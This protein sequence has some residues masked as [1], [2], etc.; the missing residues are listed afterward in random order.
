MTQEKKLSRDELIRQVAAHP[1]GKVKVAVTDID[2]ILRGKYIHKEKFLSIVDGGFGFCDVVF[3]WDSSDLSYDNTDFTGW[4]TGYPDAKASLDLDTFRQ[5]P[6][7]NDV[8][9]FLADFR[10]AEDEPSQI[11]PRNLLKAIRGR[12]EK[13]NF[14]ATFSQEFEWFN[15][16]E[17]PE[18]LEAKGYL[19]PRPLTPGMFG[20]SV[21]RASRNKDFFNDLFDLLAQFDVPI[22]GL[23]TETGPGTY[24]AAILYTEVLEAADRAVLFKTGTKEIAMN[25]GIIPTF[26]AKWHPEYPGCSGHLHQSLWDREQTNNLF[27]DPSRADKMSALMKSYLAGLLHCLP[28]VL[29]MYAPTINSYKRLVEGAWAP[30][31]VTWGIDNRTTTIRALPGSMKSTRI[32]LRVVGSDANPYL[33][34][35]ASLASGLYGIENNLNLEIEMTKGNGYN[36]TKDGVLANTLEQATRLM[37]ES[38]LAHQLFGEGFTR[39][40]IQTREWEWK[41][42]LKAVTDW[43][44]RRY[45]E[46]I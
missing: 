12:A 22:E 26:M 11:C 46:I 25:Y 37:K 16:R 45:F 8:P 13:L 42:H 21:L 27:Y 6:W 17:E 28:Y 19:N 36:N 20:Y 9:F 43:E 3:G 30:T 38:E 29:P 35:A 15:F 39:H 7:D 1:A 2:G 40:F 33:A 34:M 32:E 23:H 14:H 4:H 31:T 41:Q 24:E 10:T 18:E 44:M 5:V